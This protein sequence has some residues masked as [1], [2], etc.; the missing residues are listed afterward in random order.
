MSQYKGL[1]Q[2]YAGAKTLAKNPVKSL[3]LAT[4][5]LTAPT[6]IDAARG[7]V[8][9][10]NTTKIPKVKGNAVLE[11]VADRFTGCSDGEYS[12]VEGKILQNI[13]RRNANSPKT[14]LTSNDVR[15]SGV[16][17]LTKRIKP[18][19]HFM[20]PLMGANSV[21]DQK[22]FIALFDTLRYTKGSLEG[23]YLFIDKTG[24][25]EGVYH[26]EH[27]TNN[28]SFHMRDGEPK[29]VFGN[30]QKY[31]RT[32]MTNQQIKSKKDRTEFTRIMRE[33]LK[34]TPGKYRELIPQKELAAML[35]QSTDVELKRLEKEIAILET[36]E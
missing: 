18:Q 4:A 10:A 20:V 2:L 14:T 12:D 28:G 31:F 1:K 25:L 32:L 7:R 8:H 13:Y 33:G 6:Y 17:V 16:Y 9:K 22:E 19:K 26:F 23:S 5:L 24:K 36:T 11:W 29:E 21:L 27:T 3:L 15:W 30:V 34:R 35:K